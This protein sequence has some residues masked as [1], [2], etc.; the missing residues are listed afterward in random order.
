VLN[1]WGD[2]EDG[3][4]LT[5]E[6]FEQ[7]R[8]G[9]E[10][11]AECTICF[12]RLS[13]PGTATQSSNRNR[14]VLAAVDN[15][16]LSCGHAFHLECAL[17]WFDGQRD[18]AKALTCP[19]C[20]RPFVDKYIDQKYNYVNGRRPSASVPR[21]R[22]NYLNT[23]LEN[24]PFYELGF[25]KLLSIGWHYPLVPD[26]S[27]SSATRAA[28]GHK[29]IYY[30]LSVPMNLEPDFDY[31]LYCYEKFMRVT[32]AAEEPTFGEWRRVARLTQLTVLGS[33]NP[34]QLAFFTYW[35]ARSHLNGI[36]EGATNLV[37]DVRR[38]RLE[39]SSWT[40]IFR[41][42]VLGDEPA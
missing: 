2:R 32:A 3:L 19:A 34:T 40:E 28:F 14:R 1:T 10:R 16:T 15:P 26:M 11:D 36:V 5:P 35:I 42:I 22:F 38:A 7:L 21:R 39:G 30:G 24:G 41:A 9:D 17:K 33:Y 4:T 13:D 31:E 25:G 29:P 8:D 18:L 6:Q 12:E 20:T 23:R 27:P 37:L